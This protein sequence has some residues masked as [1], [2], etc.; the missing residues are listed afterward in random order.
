VL[1]LL[2]LPSGYLQCPARAKPALAA[3]TASAGRDESF[4]QLNAYKVFQNY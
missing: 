3:V 1:P 4:M 2:L